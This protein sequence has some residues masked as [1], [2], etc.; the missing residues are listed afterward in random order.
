[1]EF[2]DWLAVTFLLGFVGL[3]LLAILDP[4]EHCVIPEALGAM[5]PNLLLISRF[6]FS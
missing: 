2:R 4:R 3:A 5:S 6:Y 1:M